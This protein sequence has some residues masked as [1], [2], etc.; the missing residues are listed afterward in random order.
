MTRVAR[1]FGVDY[2]ERPLM[3]TIS[4]LL[5]IPH[6]ST[7]HGGTVRSDFLR[8]VADALGVSHA[9]LLKDE[10]LAAVWEA[11]HPGRRMPP[12]HYSPG[13][14]VKNDVLEE[15]VD[16]IVRRAERAGSPAAD[17]SPTQLVD[18]RRPL[19]RQVALRE[20]QDKF[21]TRVLEAY[22]GQCAISGNR[23]PAVLDAAHVAPYRG[24]KFNVVPNGLCLRRDLH[25]L[26][27]RGLLAIHE[28]SLAIKL[29]GVLQTSEYW[30]LA[31][32][33]IRLPRSRA[34]HPS[35]EALRIHR[36]ASRLT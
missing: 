13:G 33:T 21:R 12:G 9:G 20:G 11:V 2:P 18:E 19:W 6:F 35:R 5:G 14:T 8:A 29:A 27:D 3:S 15:I 23:V 17:F 26:F 28:E 31:G 22:G 25:G 1:A 4:D 10:V 36:E 24:T 7:A 16:G 34:D 30:S 32:Q